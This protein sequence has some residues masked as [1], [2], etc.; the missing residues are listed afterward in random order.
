MCLEFDRPEAAAELLKTGNPLSSFFSFP[1][2]FAFELA[3][4]EGGLDELPFAETLDEKLFGQ[5]VDRFRADA[6]QPHAELKYIVIIFCARVDL[7]NAVHDFPQRNPPPK[8]AH[9]HRIVL[10][11]N[12]H[13]LA[14]A[15]D[16][17]V[18]GVINHFLKQDVT[19]VVTM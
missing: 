14:R 13:L 15:H 11:R 12:L 10:D 17:F 7:R 1:F 2:L 8:I 6:V 18:N 4:F 5:R 9:C 19:A 3:L 16:E